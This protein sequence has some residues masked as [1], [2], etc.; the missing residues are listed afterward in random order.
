MVYIK[1]NYVAQIYNTKLDH[2][3]TYPLESEVPVDGAVQYLTRILVHFIGLKQY[4]FG[5]DGYNLNDFSKIV[6]FIYSTRNT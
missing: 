6:Q 1:Y 2:I 3:S 4:V 5:N